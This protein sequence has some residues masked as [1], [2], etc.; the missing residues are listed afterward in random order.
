MT[1]YRLSQDW[2]EGTSLQ[3][4]SAGGKGE[5]ATSGDTT[6]TAR[7]FDPVN[8]ALWSV[9]GSAFNSAPSATTSVGTSSNYYT[10]S[11]V[12][13][14]ADVQAWLNS[15]ATNFGWVLRGDETKTSSANV[16]DSREGVANVQPLL[17]INYNPVLPPPTRRESWLR[18]YFP[19]PGTYVDDSADYDGDGLANLTEYAFAFSPLVPNP[20][21]SG[22]QL[23][24]GQSGGNVTL[25]V[26][27]RRDPRAIDLTY[28]LQTS[29]DLV[30]WTTIVQS[31]AGSTPTG[32]GFVSETDAPGESPVRV[33]SAAEILTSPTRR[34]ARL[35]IIRSQ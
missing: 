4:G 24:T 34:F 25:T 28:Y 20:S 13:L 5:T 22:L 14:A 27:F 35:M 26:T 6:W 29:S 17:Q 33:V 32:S 1:L 9:A 15:S 18:Q 8:P 7:F 16:F 10:W 11:S 31:V 23:H 12:Q 3:I 19:I 21:G 30:N 2:G